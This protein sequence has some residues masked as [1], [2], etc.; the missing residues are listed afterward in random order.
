MKILK[1]INKCE[2]WIFYSLFWIIY[3]VLLLPFFDIEIYHNI[4]DNKYYLRIIIFTYFISIAYYISYMFT[5]KNIF[6]KIYHYII[7]LVLF[8]IITGLQ[9][10]NNWAFYVYFISLSLLM[11][12]HII[13]LIYTMKKK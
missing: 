6:V 9:F 7:L 10:V 11:I 12:I 2:G 8:T 3:I 13:L 1:W 5:I 4:N